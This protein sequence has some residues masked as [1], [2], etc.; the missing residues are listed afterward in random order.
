MP[1]CNSASRSLDLG[2]LHG[3]GRPYWNN[4]GPPNNRVSTCYQPKSI[5]KTQVLAQRAADVKKNIYLLFCAW[6]S[7]F[8]PR[9]D[10]LPQH[11]PT[12]PLSEYFKCSCD[13]DSL[14]K[15]YEIK[16]HLQLVRTSREKIE[17]QS[18]NQWR[19]GWNK[20][21]RKINN[22]YS[23][24]FTHITFVLLSKAYLLGQSEFHFVNLL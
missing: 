1:F 10:Q 15:W 16:A 14:R 23:L 4:Q 6:G 2:D 20:K 5:G 8:E 21:I 19:N 12:A 22:Q 11:L 3:F 24:S 7:R 9:Q 13:V 18:D 17:G